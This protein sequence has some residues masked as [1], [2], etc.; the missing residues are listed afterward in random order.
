MLGSCR[1]GRG[2]MAHV[3]TDLQDVIRGLL[4]VLDHD[5]CKVISQQ[6]SPSL[7][8]HLV[9]L[10]VDHLV[11]VK[12]VPEQHTQRGANTS[13][14]HDIIS[15]QTCKARGKCARLGVRWGNRDSPRGRMH[16]QAASGGK[17]DR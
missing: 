7:C 16:N 15:E 14:A 3:P 1:R 2:C 10:G 17:G 8:V 4:C 5:G 11:V 9:T 13:S 6:G 12:Q